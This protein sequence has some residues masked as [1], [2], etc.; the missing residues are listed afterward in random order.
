MFMFG[1]PLEMINFNA[2]SEAPI[3]EQW[4]VHPMLDVLVN[5]YLLALGEFGLDNFEPHPYTGACLTFFILATIITQLT[6]MN[7]L[8]A[9]MADTYARVSENRQ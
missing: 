9:V 3:I 7:M 1:L 2:D 4:T 6:M 5:Q 8:I